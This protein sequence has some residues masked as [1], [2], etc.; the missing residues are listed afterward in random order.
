VVGGGL[1]TNVIVDL[2]VHTPQWPR[3]RVLMGHIAQ[4]GIITSKSC[5]RLKTQEHPHIQMQRHSENGVTN[6]QAFLLMKLTG[7]M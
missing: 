5:N 6:L 7:H 3:H 1:L 2:L 4:A